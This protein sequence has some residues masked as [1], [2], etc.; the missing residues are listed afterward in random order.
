MPAAVSNIREL[1]DPMLA[2]VGS[3]PVLDNSR[4][5]KS[6][7]MPATIDVTTIFAL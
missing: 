5:L 6:E 4:S 7:T 1:H 3:L 2:S